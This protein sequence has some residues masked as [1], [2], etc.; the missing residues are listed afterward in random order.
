V[1][2]FR[3]WDQVYVLGTSLLR[4][5]LRIAWARQIAHVVGRDCEN[6]EQR[7]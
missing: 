1:Y 7:R 5:Q 2:T 4:S 3:L 6:R